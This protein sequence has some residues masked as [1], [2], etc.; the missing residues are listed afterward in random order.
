[1][2]CE[3]SLIGGPYPRDICEVGASLL[4]IFVANLKH[5]NADVCTW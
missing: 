2:N 4:G 5:E 1:M 3:S